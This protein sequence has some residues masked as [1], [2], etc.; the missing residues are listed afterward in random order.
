MS[1]QLHWILSAFIKL[2]ISF[3]AHAS[4]I[5]VSKGLQHVLMFVGLP[6]PIPLRDS[7]VAWQIALTRG[8][9]NEGVE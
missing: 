7:F 2:Q 4:M 6:S 8:M 1:T 9:L 3:P 5:V